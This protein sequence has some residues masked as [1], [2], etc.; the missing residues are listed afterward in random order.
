MATKVFDVPVDDAARRVGV[1]VE[2][3]KRYARMG[4]IPAVKTISGRWVFAGD[5]LD[6]LAV[7]A[8]VVDA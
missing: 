7:H 6:S 3:M 1:H 5:D 4:K 8:V 2:T